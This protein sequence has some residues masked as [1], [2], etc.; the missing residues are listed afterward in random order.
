MA[1]EKLI[2]DHVISQMT[3]VIE[4]DLIETVSTGRYKLH[5]CNTEWA[6]IGDTIAIEGVNYLV[7]DFVINEYLIVTG[8][9]LPTQLYFQLTA[10]VFEHGNHRKVAVERDKQKDKRA[11]TPMVYMMITR[12][13]RV[14]DY[15][16]PYSFDGEARFFF[17]G[18]YN[19]K[20]DD[21]D[22]HQQEVIEPMRA[23]A[24]YFREKWNEREDIF[25]Q[26]TEC[27]EQDWMNFGSPQVWGN[28]PRIFDENLSG[29][30]NAFRIL[31]VADEDCCESIPA[32]SCLPSVLK[33]DGVFAEAIS[34]GSSLD[35][36]VEDQS[37]NTPTYSYNPTTDTLTVQT[38]GAGSFTYDLYL[39]GV[40]TGQDITIDGTDITINLD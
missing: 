27:A 28:N 7:V 24:K 10:P 8:P 20:K 19:E 31:C 2:E 39:N 32:Q 9:S 15:D 38:G 33:F 3:P 17:L 4:L 25:E 1:I 26:I 35:I 37:G 6:T 23:M 18:T 14:K 11:I 29:V 34:S 16:S 22:T 21:I 40:D 12:N 30:E 5:S 36:A 13:T